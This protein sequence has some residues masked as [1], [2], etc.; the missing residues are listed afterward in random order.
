M[1]GKATGKHARNARQA[2]VAARCLNAQLLVATQTRC[3]RLLVLHTRIR[4]Y[5]RF[6]RTLYVR[7][8]SLQNPVRTC[9][10]VGTLISHGR[11]RGECLERIW[12]GL[13]A[14]GSSRRKSNATKHPPATT[15]LGGSANRLFTRTRSRETRP[16][17][18]ASAMAWCTFRPPR[19][20]PRRN[21]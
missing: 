2:R 9:T 3:T 11:S 14:D 13:P 15:P 21:P 4:L 17:S 12:R 18:M 7:V 1:L 6:F 5:G 10:C 8:R 20:A 16:F 19:N